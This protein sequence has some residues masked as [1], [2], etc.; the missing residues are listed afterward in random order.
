KVGLDGG[1]N[2]PVPSF[3][4]VEGRDAWHQPHGGPPAVRTSVADN[5]GRLYVNVHVGGIVRSDDDGRSWQPTI[6]IDNDVHQVATVPSQ[7]GRIV[8]ATARGLAT[9]DDYGKTW[10]ILDDGLHAP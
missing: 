3:D 10:R 5:E 9:S 6:D 4:E 1:G 8:A 7:P 2:E